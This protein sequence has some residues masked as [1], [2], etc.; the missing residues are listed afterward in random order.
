[1]GPERS[2]GKDT[3]KKKTKEF[4]IEIMLFVIRVGAIYHVRERG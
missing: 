3:R 4:L 1:L 2:V